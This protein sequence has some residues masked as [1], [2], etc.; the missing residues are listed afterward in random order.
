MKSGTMPTQPAPFEEKS[1]AA[2]LCCASA[3][4]ANAAQ[5]KPLKTPRVKNCGLEWNVGTVASTVL[6]F[7]ATQALDG[8]ACVA[9]ACTP[10]GAA[11]IL[12]PTRT[13]DQTV[14]LRCRP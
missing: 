10:C 2:A 13:G 3:A 1:G 5:I 8:A 6:L 4:D 7:A 12:P 9:R 14:I 11:R